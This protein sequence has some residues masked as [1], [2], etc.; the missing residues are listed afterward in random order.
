MEML[1]VRLTILTQQFRNRIQRK[2]NV[3]DTEVNPQFLTLH[4]AVEV[5]EKQFITQTLEQHHW[6]KVQTARVL[7]IGRKT[8]YRKMKQ[9][10]LM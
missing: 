10:G 1:Q 7:G 9:F 2:Q 8:L 4:E 3:S 5:F 6:H